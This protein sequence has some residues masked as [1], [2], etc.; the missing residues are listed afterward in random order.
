MKLIIT[1]EKVYGVVIDRKEISMAVAPFD[2]GIG[3]PSLSLITGI[4]QLFVGIGPGQVQALSAG[5][6]GDVLTADPSLPAGVKWASGG[7]GASSLLY[8]FSGT[9][10]SAGDVL[11][12]DSNNDRAFKTTSAQFDPR[13]IGVAGATIIAGAEGKVINFPGTIT[14]VNC[15]AGQVRRGEYLVSSS[16]VKLAKSA[17][18][19]R[20]NATFAI[21]LTAKA[22]GSAGSVYAMLQPQMTVATGGGYS[23]S[24]GGSNAAANSTNAEKFFSATEIWANVPT[25]ALPSAKASSGGFAN[26]GIAG[27]AGAGAST[28]TPD[29]ITYRTPFATDICAAGAAW[30]ASRSY[31]GRGG[32]NNG[33]TASY[34]GGSGTA[35]STEVLKWVYSTD[36]P[37]F[38]AGVLSTTRRASQ[39]LGGSGV[40]HFVSGYNA[41][42]TDKV[43][44]T[45]DTVS[46]QAGANALVIHYGMGTL[47]F[48]GP[49]V[50]YAAS[51]VTYKVTHGTSILTNVASTPP[52]AYGA[53]TC[54]A[55]MCD[56]ISKG[57][58]G[59]NTT[60]P[61]TGGDSFNQVTENWA[62]CV[63]AVPIVPRGNTSY[64]NQNS[65]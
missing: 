62:S 7:S 51:D 29:T 27:Y 34:I 28:S 17:G 44:F 49:N 54:P 45:T 15:D 21:A 59:G 3:S 30:P 55:A 11:I 16:T 36:T 13:V 2:L 10:V 35:A 31:T 8:N 39:Q 33:N 46:A 26:Q 61:Y 42:N 4:G 56:G 64:F 5:N 58:L 18:P 41:V 65:I 48:I 25:A 40:G 1:E 37:A 52:S 6:L 19:V 12:P 32:V 50:S 53:N 60:A 47:N 23:Y 57:Y 24:Q 20:T 38:I 9:T 63:G 22:A 14:T 43:V